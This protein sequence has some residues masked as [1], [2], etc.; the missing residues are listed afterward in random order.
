MLTTMSA[1]KESADRMIASVEYGGKTS[2]D[3]ISDETK[4][5]WVHG[6]VII[7]VG[8]LLNHWK[9]FIN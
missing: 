1:I 5:I 8:N 3:H 4:F 7:I 2:S 6:T 9:V